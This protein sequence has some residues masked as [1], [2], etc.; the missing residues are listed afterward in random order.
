MKIKL[1]VT[2]LLL[3]GH[4]YANAQTSVSDTI[5]SQHTFRL[6][7]NTE[8]TES[9]TVVVTEEPAQKK[10]KNKVKVR[11][12]KN[13]EY[14]LALLEVEFEME[15]YRKKIKS[16]GEETKKLLL[17]E[18]INK[19]A[20]ITNVKTADYN[21]DYTQVLVIL[22]DDTEYRWICDDESK[23]KDLV[24]EGIVYE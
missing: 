22:P 11:K 7:N 5:R 3:G 20:S 14:R 19:L 16:S 12:P 18:L 4:L 13:M 17:Q 1:I 10:K 6:H 23:Y 15:N 21:Q 9:K 24:K 2:A 8:V